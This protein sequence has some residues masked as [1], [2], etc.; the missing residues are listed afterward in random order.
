MTYGPAGPPD[1]DGLD[2]LLRPA[3]VSTWR[4]ADTWTTSH[5]RARPLNQTGLGWTVAADA[6]AAVAFDRDVPL[7]QVHGLLLPLA[8]TGIWWAQW[9]PGIVLAS[10]DA[11]TD[12]TAARAIAYTTL[13]GSHRT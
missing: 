12:P 3:A 8:V 11:V 5:V 9:A 10:F 13:A 6:A 1:Y 4:A 2:E 7:D